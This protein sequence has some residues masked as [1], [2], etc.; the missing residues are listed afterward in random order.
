M[1]ALLNLLSRCGAA[2]DIYAS[3]VWVNNKK[4]MDAGRTIS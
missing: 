2:A 3:N 1:V 4:V